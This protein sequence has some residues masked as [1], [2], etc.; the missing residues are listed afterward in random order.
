VLSNIHARVPSGGKI[1]GELRIL[2]WLHG[3]DAPA[4]ASAGLKKRTSTSQQGIIRARIFG[5]TVASVMSMLRRLIS[6]SVVLTQLLR[7][8]ESRLLGS[9][10]N[11]TV[12][13]KVGLTPQV[14]PMLFLCAAGGCNIHE[15]DGYGWTSRAFDVRTSGESDSCSWGFGG[16]LFS[17]FANQCGLTQVI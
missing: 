9:A 15:A 8:C 5:F 6:K 12:A 7:R 1:D 14:Y 10:D 2:H 3:G 13:A 17:G 4:K 16:I 11:L